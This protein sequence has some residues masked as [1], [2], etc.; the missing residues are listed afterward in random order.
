MHFIILFLLPFILCDSSDDSCKTA[1]EISIFAGKLHSPS[2]FLFVFAVFGVLIMIITLGLLVCVYFDFFNYEWPNKLLYGEFAANDNS[3]SAVFSIKKPFCTVADT[4]VTYQNIMHHNKLKLP[5]C[6]SLTE[7]P[8]EEVPSFIY[9]S[10]MAQL[11]KNGH[12]TEFL[13]SS[14]RSDAFLSKLVVV[15]TENMCNKTLAAKSSLGQEV[16]PQDLIKQ[17][18]AIIAWILDVIN[19]KVEGYEILRDAVLLSV[20]EVVSKYAPDSLEAPVDMKLTEKSA[21]ALRALVN[22]Y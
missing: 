11:I 18:C 6:R 21:E 7:K 4:D 20:N 16:D 15:G 5:L 14:S 2:Q 12:D 1:S 3:C 8:I 9:N 10:I 13:G 17:Q 19:N 22:R